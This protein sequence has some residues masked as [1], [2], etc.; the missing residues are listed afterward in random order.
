MLQVRVSGWF[1]NPLPEEALP[2]A[3][4]HHLRGERVLRDC[5]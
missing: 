5:Q 3:V 4:H 2:E 1:D